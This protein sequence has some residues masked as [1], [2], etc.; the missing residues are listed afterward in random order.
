MIKLRGI[1]FLTVIV[2][3]A[4]KFD[5]SAQSTLQLKFTP[6]GIHPFD[7]KNSHL[8]ENRIDANGIFITEPCFILSYESF[9]RSDVFAIRGMV[10]FL[11]DAASKPA[12]LIHLGAKQRLI[13]V[14]RNSLSI[15]I[16]GNIYGREC[17]DRIPHYETDNSWSENGKWEYKLGFMAEIEYALFLN[18]K[19][20]LTLSI[21][22]GHQPNTFTFTIG[23]KYWISSIIK[24]PKKC[25]SCPFSKTSKHWNP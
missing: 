23:Y 13:Q 5:L 18:D 22:Y 2:F 19:N 1:A 12:I 25:G 10:G 3:I 6:I 24:H 17:W 8:F 20:D 11:S 21:L 9:L 4:I 16:G 14:W 15:G 7:E